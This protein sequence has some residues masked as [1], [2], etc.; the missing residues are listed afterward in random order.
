MKCFKTWQIIIVHVWKKR[1]D[2][3]K[4]SIQRWVTCNQC[5]R[6]LTRELVKLFQRDHKS[7]KWHSNLSKKLTTSSEGGYCATEICALWFIHFYSVCTIT[8]TPHTSSPA[9]SAVQIKTQRAGVTVG[10]RGRKR[11]K[12]RERDKERRG[13]RQGGGGG[14]NIKKTPTSV[15]QRDT[16]VVYSE[17]PS[18]PRLTNDSPG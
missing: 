2:K 8:H 1:S 5:G 4:G 3:L 13:G 10:S 12:R 18:L 15:C 14:A 9:C 17:S 6:H 11:D 7:A 16:P